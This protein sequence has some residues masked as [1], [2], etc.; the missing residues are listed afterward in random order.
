MPR[1]IRH[2][3]DM[4][5]LSLRPPNEAARIAARLRSARKWRRRRFWLLVRRLALGCRPRRRR[6]T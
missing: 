6:L 5:D 4:G 3:E 1:L 2:P